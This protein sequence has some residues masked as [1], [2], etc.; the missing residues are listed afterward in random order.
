MGNI[1]FNIKLNTI[2]LGDK[3]SGKTTL[4]S[5]IILKRIPNIYYK[6][7][8]YNTE[9]LKLNNNWI[10]FWDLGGL[11]II[12]DIW[13]F[14]YNTI[15]IN[16]LILIF[17]PINLEKIDDYFLCKTIETIKEIT[18]EI[19]FK[20][21]SILIIINQTDKDNLY[22]KDEDKYYD[23]VNKYKKIFKFDKIPQL[24][25]DIIIINLLFKDDYA[26]FWKSYLNLLDS[27]NDN[28]AENNN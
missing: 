17:G 6:T 16:I 10:Q 19:A 9:V 23:F 7:I 27:L 28:R 11:D 26:L 8:G 13:K 18:N 14:F 25:K 24:K 21:K 12:K 22:F 15:E 3:R 4:L 1:N 20:D 5:N 2:I